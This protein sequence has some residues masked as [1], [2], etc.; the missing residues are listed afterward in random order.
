LLAGE[1]CE[2]SKI[3]STFAFSLLASGPLPPAAFHLL[4]G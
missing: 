2:R 4:A 1:A 3:S